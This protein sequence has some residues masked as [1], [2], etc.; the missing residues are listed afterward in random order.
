VLD[1]D[2]QDVV[3]APGPA[4]ARAGADVLDH[5]VGDVHALPRRIDHRL[6]DRVLAAETGNRPPGH[7]HAHPLARAV[8]EC[9]AGREDAAE[10]DEAR[11][12]RDERDEGDGRLDDGLAARGG[13]GKPLASHCGVLAGPREQSTCP[14]DFREIS[15]HQ[16]RR[17]ARG[18]TSPMCRP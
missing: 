15:L 4:R 18:G 14:T 13:M 8:L 11:E 16:G 10:I 6:L 2:D 1:G 3:R 7:A 9:L 12:Q 5:D 17:P